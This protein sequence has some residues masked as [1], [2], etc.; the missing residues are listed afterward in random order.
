MVISIQIQPRNGFDPIQL[1]SDDFDPIQLQNYLNFCDN[2]GDF[3]PIHDFDSNFCDNFAHYFCRHISPLTHSSILPH[4][5]VKM[6]AVEA[7]NKNLKKDIN[8]MKEDFE[9]TRALLDAQVCG[10][11]CM[12]VG[13]SR[14]LPH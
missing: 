14:W 5:L 6:K 13:Y 8:K 11:G 4:R 1:Q 10:W 2:N 3:D 7:E 9:C 12:V